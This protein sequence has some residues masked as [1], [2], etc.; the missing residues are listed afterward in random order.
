MASEDSL[1]DRLRDAASEIESVANDV[2]DV[3][4]DD[5]LVE[6]YR[7]EFGETPSLRKLLADIANTTKRV[8]VMV[9]VQEAVNGDD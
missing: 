1:A 6:A 5:E 9:E 3:D 2:G 4:F 7:D 8:S